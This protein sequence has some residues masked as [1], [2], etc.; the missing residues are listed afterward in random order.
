MYTFMID[1]SSNYIDSFI[2]KK[3]ISLY[4]IILFA[5]KPI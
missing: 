1:I 3:R 5:L 4:W 2:I